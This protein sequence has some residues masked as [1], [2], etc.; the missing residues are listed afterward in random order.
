M[1]SAPMVFEI[2]PAEPAVMIPSGIRRLSAWLFDY[3]LV[4]VYMGVLFFVAFILTGG[5]LE[6]E[7]LSTPGSRQLF[8]SLTLTLPVLLAFTIFEASTW[9]GTVG[10]RATRL[11]VT[12]RNLRRIGFG[13]SLVRSALKLLPW[14]LASTF[15]HRVP[16]VGD[17]PAVAWAALIGSGTLTAVYVGG[18]FFRSRRPLY[19]LVAGTRVVQTAEPRS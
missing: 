17:I 1:T 5:K 4:A 10:K 12:D 13:R 19:D 18:L 6:I 8:V 11:L 14:E 7:G 2:A 9:Q 15:V 3:F 16:K